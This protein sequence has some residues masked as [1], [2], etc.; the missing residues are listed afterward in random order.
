MIS[1]PRANALHWR[2]RSKPPCFDGFVET[3]SLR[4]AFPTE[5]S[6][7]GAVEST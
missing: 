1:G 7:R 4:S 5:V 3:V 6:A 2:V